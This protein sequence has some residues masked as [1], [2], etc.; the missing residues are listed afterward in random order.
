MSHELRTPLNAILGFSE[1]MKSEI[2]GAH[3]VPA[4]KDYSA[5]IHNSGVHL[6]NLINEILDLS[7]SAPRLGAERALLGRLVVRRVAQREHTVIVGETCR[8][9]RAQWLVRLFEDLG[10]HSGI[11]HRRELFRYALGLDCLVGAAHRE[12][13]AARLQALQHADRPRCHLRLGL[14]PPG[15]QTFEEGR[16]ILGLDHERAAG[17][18]AAPLVDAGLQPGCP[19]GLHQSGETLILVL[20]PALL[21]AALVGWLIDSGREWY[22]QAKGAEIGAPLRAPRLLVDAVAIAFFSIAIGASGLFSA[23][24]KGGGA[25]PSASPADLGHPT[26]SAKGVKYDL[27]KFAVKAGEAVELTFHNEDVGVPHNVAIVAS[28]GTK[29]FSGEKIAGDATVTYE[30]PALKEGAK[31]TFICEVHANMKGEVDVLP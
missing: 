18:V 16:Q 26:L 25:V 28:D 10:A 30:I 29:L 24:A 8:H 1:V 31:Y 19:G 20:V 22:H 11:A 17:A 4:Y 14:V 15:G 7:L 21:G 13:R 6:L 5:D 23:S 3:A 2:F 12:R 27:A 9:I